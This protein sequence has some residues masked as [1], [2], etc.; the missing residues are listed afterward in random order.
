[1]TDWEKNA[2]LNGIENDMNN[3]LMLRISKI[4]PQKIQLFIAYRDL[5]SRKICA[6][7]RLQLSVEKS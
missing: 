3:P 1:M 7:V 5:M 2:G 4:P 6:T